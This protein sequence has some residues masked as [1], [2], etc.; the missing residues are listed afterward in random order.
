MLKQ[1]NE[2]KWDKMYGGETLSSLPYSVNKFEKAH[3]ITFERYEE[4]GIGGCY[5]TFIKIS[6]NKYFLQGF[7]DKDNQE[8][9]VS[10][11]M[12]GCNPSPK[13]SLNDIASTLNIAIESMPW[14]REDLST[15]R[16]MLTR[17]GDDG[18][19]V[20]IFRTHRKIVADWAMSQYEKPGHKQCYFVIEKI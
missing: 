1:I 9:G 11:E 3:G 15:P 16:W 4:G 10:L 19:E 20:E 5:C 17:Q 8:P 18:N 2:D 6:K 13:H 7:G 12:D 14:V